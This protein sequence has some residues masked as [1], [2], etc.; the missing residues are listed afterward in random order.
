MQPENRNEAKRFVTMIDA[1]YDAKVKF[2][3]S[4]EAVPSELYKGGDGAFE[5]ERTISR[6]IEMQSSEYMGLPHDS[7]TI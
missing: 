2:I 1:F 7:S 6:L 4:A 3:C 5:F